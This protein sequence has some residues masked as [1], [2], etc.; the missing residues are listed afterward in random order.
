M[1]APAPRRS[2]FSR[3]PGTVHEAEHGAD[4]LT[5][6]EGLAEPP[7]II[8]LDISMPIMSGDECLRTLRAR[9]CTV[10]VLMS[11]GYDADDVASHRVVPGETQFLQKPYTARALL[12]AIA[13][14]APAP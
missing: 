1:R 11:S 2:A 8:V 3:A 6:Y 13:E 5:V 14:L 7:R 9:G 12:G 4:A 10:P